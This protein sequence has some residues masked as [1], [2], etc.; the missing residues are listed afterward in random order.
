MDTVNRT[1]YVSATGYVKVDRDLSPG[2]ETRDRIDTVRAHVSVRYN[3]ADTGYGPRF[4]RIS[5]HTLGAKRGRGHFLFILFII[6]RS[7]IFRPK[8]PK[9]SAIL[10]DNIR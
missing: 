1:V 5:Q 9:G 8:I 6:V 3:V 4:Y 10:I 2:F 7:F